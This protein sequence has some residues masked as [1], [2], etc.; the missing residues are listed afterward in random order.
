MSS[1]QQKFV[2]SHKLRTIHRATPS[3]E[4][5]YSSTEP[6]IDHYSDLAVFL[7]NRFQLGTKVENIVAGDRE[8]GN[9]SSKNEQPILVF[10]HAGIAVYKWCGD[11]DATDAV[12]QTQLVPSSIDDGAGHV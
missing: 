1:I 9:D 10:R 11:P 12:V 3:S 7:S 6:A 2:E 4:V 5:Q 8:V